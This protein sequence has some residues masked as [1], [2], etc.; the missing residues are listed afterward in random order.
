M[1][2]VIIGCGLIG[3]K[4]AKQLGSV[5]LL[6]ACDLDAEKAQALAAQH[7]GAVAMTD[8]RAAAALPGAD[9]VMVSTTHDQL[10]PIGMA[11]LQ[12]GKHVLLEK[13]GARTRAELLP[14]AAEAQKRGRTVKV[15]FNHRF[16]PSFLKAREIL[17]GPEAGPLMYI[18][19]R[20]GHGGRIGY[21]K[22]WRSKPELSG[23]GELIDQGMHL[24]DLSRMFLGEFSEASGYTPTYFWDMPVDDN[25]FML[26]KT[27][28]GQAAWLHATW[29]EWKNCFSFEIYARHAKIQIEGLGGSYGPEKLIHYQMKPELGPPDSKTYEFPAEDQ[30]WALEFQEWQQAIAEGRRPHGDITDCLAALG[31]VDRIYGRG[32]LHGS[33]A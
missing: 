31:V 6:A 3:Q 9:L 21:D 19:A 16:H 10:A 2:A 7:P 23:G 8:W 24:I 5:K 29:T 28:S 25:A 32:P 30:S 13:P 17:A 33:E 22:E 26:L 15:G 27:A 20:Y 18:R 11:A 4:R 1:N 12:A 14:L